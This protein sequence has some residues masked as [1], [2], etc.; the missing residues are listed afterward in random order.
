M[1]EVKLEC[2]NLI[3]MERLYDSLIVNINVT[4]T[5]VKQVIDK[6]K[7]YIVISR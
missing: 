2:K 7:Y 3:A 6:G 4:K 5:D 1:I